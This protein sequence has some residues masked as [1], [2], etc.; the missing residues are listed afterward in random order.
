MSVANAARDELR[1]LLGRSLVGAQHRRPG[2]E[3]APPA[4]WSRAALSGRLAEL[5][6]QGSL[7][8]LTIAVS[9]VLDAQ[10]EGETV[11]WIGL[12]ESS[13][14][15]PDVA[16]SGVDLEALVVVRC[17]NGR[18]VARSADRLARSGAF[19]LIVCDLGA[20]AHVPM[21]LQTRL[22]GLAQK[23]DCSILFITEKRG[24]TSS[25]GSLVSLR[26][27]ARRTSKVD[28]SFLCSMRTLK[29]KRAGAG[30]RHEVDCHGPAGLC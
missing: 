17:P 16:R 12:V 28:G 29:D 19:G 26:G 22:V 25:L 18:A 5:S 6:G 21:P 2:A 8:T 23:H 14:Y 7:A 27:E 3:A 30:W 13:F 15:P 11:A 9:L 10:Q 24:E 4:R 20:S 1:A